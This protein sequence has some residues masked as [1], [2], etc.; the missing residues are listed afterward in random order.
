MN[1]SIALSPFSEFRGQE[2]ISR[3]AL[4]IFVSLISVFL[5]P[6]DILHINSTGGGTH[7]DR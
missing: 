7:V 2:H 6:G 3:L 4:G 5:R 1:D